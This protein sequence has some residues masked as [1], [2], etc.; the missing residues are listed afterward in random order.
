MMDETNLSGFQMANKDFLARDFAR[1]MGKQSREATQHDIP[2]KNALK[3]Y[4]RGLNDLNIASILGVSK[5]DV[6][7]WRIANGLKSNMRKNQ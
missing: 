4:R 5:A 6:Y 2:H 3:L 7:R 1:T